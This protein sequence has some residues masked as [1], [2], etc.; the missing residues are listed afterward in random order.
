MA[1]M[2]R[3]TTL[4]VRTDTDNDAL[5]V[6]D[7]IETVLV[8]DSAQ[9]VIIPEGVQVVRLQAGKPSAGHPAPATRDGATD[10]PLWLLEHAGSERAEP[11]QRPK[12]DAMTVTAAPPRPAEAERSLS[13]PSVPDSPPAPAVAAD[14]P[15]A[16]L[17]SLSADDEPDVFDDV[18]LRP[19]AG[20][21]RAVVR[22]Q[23]GRNGTAGRPAEQLRQ[24][25]VARGHTH[26]AHGH[27]HVVHP[28]WREQFQLEH[29][30]SRPMTRKAGRFCAD[31]LCCWLGV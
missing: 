24:P 4:S 26:V 1:S 2:V 9:R 7:G 5:R 3:E 18:P 31:V 23:P 15:R 10:S 21:E 29:E 16:P 27:A 22:E 25:L 12:R 30:H 17:A 6:P 11:L 28:K 19:P 14:E 8:N 13:L 20:A